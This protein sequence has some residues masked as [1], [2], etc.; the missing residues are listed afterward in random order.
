MT[1]NQ[2]T[3]LKQLQIELRGLTSPLSKRKYNN[4]KAKIKAI[5]T[6]KYE[7]TKTEIRKVNKILKK[8]TPTK[9]KKTIE[10]NKQRLQKTKQ[11]IIKRSN[12]ILRVFENAYAL[13]YEG[14]SYNGDP[15]NWSV[16]IPK[17]MDIKKAYMPDWKNKKYD[18]T[19]KFEALEFAKLHAKVSNEENDNNYD[20]EGMMNPRTIK[21]GRL[22]IY[23]E[24]E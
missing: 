1:I 9:S 4:T 16:G 21:I 5:R 3:L 15:L 2:K 23:K 14:Y 12:K 7:L 8:T 6:G 19:N 24:E 22:V 17:E 11:T 20:E 13:Q 18:L 10:K